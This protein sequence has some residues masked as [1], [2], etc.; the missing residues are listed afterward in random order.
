MKQ[1]AARAVRV[2]GDEGARLGAEMQ[3][4]TDGEK[5]PG[6]GWLRAILALIIGLTGATVIW[7]AA[8]FN[9]ELIGSSS[10]TD[11]Y[12][13]PAV[14][15]IVLVLML[16]VNPVLRKMHPR[17]ALS[18]RQLALAMGI[19][20]VACCLPG[21][22]LLKS[23]PYSVANIPNVV[24]ENRQIAD[25]YKEMAPPKS[26]FPA[27]V[28]Y[29]KEV[30][31]SAEFVHKLPEGESVPWAAWLGPL[32]S[33]GG[34]L[35]AAWLMMIGIALIVLP[36]WRKNERLPFPLLSL[37]EALIEPPEEG[38]TFPPLLRRGA[39]WAAMVMVFGLYFLA[40]LKV[41]F[42]G[43][44]PAIPLEWR[45]YDVFS[46]GVLRYIPWYIKENH[47]YFIFIGVAFF[48]PSRIG[49]S[50]WFFEVLY[51][52]HWT[53]QAAY[54]P[55]TYWETVL[56]HRMGAMWALAAVVL[57]LGRAH[58]AH[59]F[60][61][62]FWRARTEEEVRNRKAGIMF[63][64]GVF[65]MLAW[66]T[67][68]VNVPF[69]WALFF[70]AFGFTVCLVVTR[71]VAETGMAF[72]RMHFNYWIMFVHMVP[73]SWVTLPVAYFARFI[74]MVFPI[75]S[76]VSVTVMATHAIGLDRD[77]S[78]R[79]QWR[80]GAVLMWTLVLGFVICGGTHI[81]M[82]YHYDASIDGTRRPLNAWGL[83]ML[84]GA[85][86]DVQAFREGRARTKDYNQV[87]HTAF[88]A[89]GAAALY[90]AC[91]A[92][93]RWPIHPIGLVMANS[94]YSTMVWV[95][96]F[97]GW[98]AKVLVLRYGGAQLYRKARVFFLGLIV[99]EVFAAIFWALVPAILA[100]LFG[101]T[102]YKVLKVQP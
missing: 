4:E 26:L 73:M 50:I 54:F 6:G 57:W 91:L 53:V 23:L 88:G 77:A 12:L 8:P 74:S 36:Q 38:H 71:V 67:F 59:V 96:I 83:G 56:Y 18:K 70:V 10:L 49:F 78:P 11:T 35:V 99:G 46:E 9:D 14:L 51:A 20:L 30:P 27:E 94:F 65:G 62:T 60:R 7:V 17:L 13:P 85:H 89:L 47:L 33:W 37:H 5:R 24:R 55:P 90:L 41:Y 84:A 31:A 2:A 21:Q 80:T 81:W 1:F 39:F 68:F 32:W 40:G 72:V 93:P 25:A 100:L 86:G 58:W 92:T 42:P 22:G 82:N 48:M 52:V 98:L 16:G 43:E 29:E 66:L 3:R 28:G 87:G 15:F 75:G 44:V 63:L 79:S 69:G 19:M 97:A 95:S 64:L 102:D 101:V 61:C 76:R 34:F 45:L